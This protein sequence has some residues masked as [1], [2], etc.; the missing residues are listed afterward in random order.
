MLLMPEGLAKYILSIYDSLL[1]IG[2]SDSRAGYL[3]T[4]LSRITTSYCI[5][6]IK[7]IW[8]KTE[9]KCKYFISFI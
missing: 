5:K 2:F 8:K 1:S 6:I 4:Y 3:G 9:R 7:Y